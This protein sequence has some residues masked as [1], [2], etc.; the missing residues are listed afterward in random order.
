MC[1]GWICH[2]Q[3]NCFW[4]NLVSESNCVHNTPT[5]VPF[6]S[7]TTYM[8]LMWFEFY[9]ER[10]STRR[11]KTLIFLAYHQATEKYVVN[12]VRLST[13]MVRCIVDVLPN[14]F[15]KGTL[16]LVNFSPPEYMVQTS[17]FRSRWTE[18]SA[19]VN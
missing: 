3:S 5:F 10:G 13:N 11:K 17:F 7:Y 16:W 2:S 12:T 1:S 14:M 6:S 18:R 9:P 4:S 19:V 8:H 15:M